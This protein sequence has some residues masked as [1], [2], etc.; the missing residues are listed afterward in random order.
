MARGRTAYKLVHETPRNVPRKAGCCVFCW[1]FSYFC[2]TYKG[3][4]KQAKKQHGTVFLLA[5]LQRLH[6]LFKRQ[7]KTFLFDKS[8]SWLYTLTTPYLKKLCTF[9]SE[10]P[11]ISTNFDFFWQK[12]G[13]RARIIRGALIFQLV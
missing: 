4:S 6:R 3:T 13:K 8:F 10:L 11:Q 9:L 12:D 1:Q 7:L 2:C 5:W